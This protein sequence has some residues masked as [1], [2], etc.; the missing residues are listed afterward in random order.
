MLCSSC[1][2]RSFEFALREVLVPI[3]DRLE[4]AVVDRDHR[5]GEQFQLAA[6]LNELPAHPANRFA[7]VLAKIGNRL[8]VRHQPAGLGSVHPIEAQRAEIKLIDKD[9]DHPDPIVFGD[10]VFEAFGE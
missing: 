8:K 3:V 4:L 6:Q 5:L 2:K 1:S 10:I 9:V 7:V